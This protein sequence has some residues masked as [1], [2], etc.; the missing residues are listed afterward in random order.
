MKKWISFEMTLVIFAAIIGLMESCTETKAEIKND[1]PLEKQ[2]EVTPKKPL[3]IAFKNYWY[4]GKA[5]ITSYALEQAR[6][7]EIRIGKAV[8]I[9]VTEPFNADKQVKVNQ[10]NTTNISVLKL[11]S[12]KKYLTGIYPYSI[13]SSSFYPISNNQQ[14]LKVTFSAQ[15]W[16][17]QVFAQLN[18]Q[19][20]FEIKSY[21]YFESEGDQ[22]LT[23]NKNV[24]ENEIWNKIRINPESLPIGEL[25]MI[26]SLEYIRLSHKALKA[27]DVT[28]IM[29]T[30]DSLN[31]YRITYPELDR[32]LEISFDS[33]FPNTIQ[34]WTESFK[35]GFG[36]KAKT[37]TSKAKKINTIKTPY[38]QQNGNNNL[39]L[40]DTL[41][42]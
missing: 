1:T 15:E 13:M 38:W 34:S 26:P 18:N 33:S 17:G 20:K 9:Y 42:L 29:T 16:C 2:V 5:E 22:T 32:T 3:T 40:R 36:D 41:G 25:K 37:M 30:T 19:E 8:L 10:K 28:T 12:T 7:G 21:S 14:A 27:Y 4:D 39:S 11:N 35:S 6:Y 23:I 31:V 24:L